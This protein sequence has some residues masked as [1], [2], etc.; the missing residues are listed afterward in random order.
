M[1]AGDSVLTS[2]PGGGESRRRPAYSLPM[3]VIFYRGRAVA[4]A[5]RERF[6]LAPRI[7]GR[8]DGDPVK[9]FVCFLVLY[10]RDV[11]AGPLPDE[12]HGYMPGRAERFARECL[13]PRRAFRALAGHSDAALAPPFGVPRDQV[14]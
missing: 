12:P 5:G 10:A 14:S 11:L 6:Y 7:A 2:T 1:A 3:T 4:L 9:T 13:L 8:A